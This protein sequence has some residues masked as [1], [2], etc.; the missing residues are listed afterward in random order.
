MRYTLH[1]PGE[2]R[3]V[4]SNLHGF[5][6][7][8]LDTGFKTKWSGFWVP[9]YKFLDYFALKV[10]GVWLDE[11]TL[12][13]VEY[14]EDFVFH[15]ETDS[16]KI[17]EKISAPP[18]LPG[19]R[20][21]LQMENK[22][23]SPKAIHAVVEPGIDIREKSEDL[24]DEDYT[25]ETTDNRLLASR[26]GKKLV[27]ESEDISDFSGRTE[28][29][30][31]YP[32]E[33]Q[34]CVIPPKPV[35]RSEIG[36]GAVE[37]FE[38][39]FKTS[40]GVFGKVES[41]EQQL[42]HELGRVFSC[43]I[44]SLENLT[45][46]RNGKGIIAGHPWFQDYWARDSFWSIMGYIDAGYFDLSR[47]ILENFAEKGISGKIG[48]EAD[49]SEEIYRADTEPLFIIAS[50]KLRRHSGTSPVIERARGKAIEKLETSENIVEHPP[51]GTW[52]DTLEREKAVEIQSL[53]LE[54]AE[55]M[56]DDRKEELEKGLEE[57]ENGEKYRDEL[58]GGHKTVNPAIPLM[59]GQAS[60][61]VAQKQ[62]EKI[63]GEFSSRYGARTRSVT[64]PG[65]ESAGYHT[66][67][68]WGLTTCWA[69]A[70]NLNY[71]K[72]Q[73]GVNMLEKL[74]SMLDRNQPGA[75][76]EVV[77]AESGELLGASE[78]A[79]SAGMLLHVADSYLLGINVGDDRVE[80]DPAGEVS[81][82]RMGK[83]VGEQSLDLEFQDG[84]VEV[85][86]D[87]ELEIR[88]GERVNGE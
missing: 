37:N 73:E 56:G 25:V 53:W 42:Q 26:K 45:Y 87:P 69:A 75:F 78:Q 76:P 10:N 54:A 11:G 61:E 55:I 35:F 23:D 64:D 77:D 13:A 84:K 70:A 66:G 86:N 74:N 52:M 27:I 51:E 43:S 59:F 81:C 15:H 39:D 68:V 71:G 3:G 88:T 38:M 34:L 85:L 46:A 9:P 19:F 80:I 62:L 8:Y 2:K 67:S 32:G 44:E 65:Y 16:M 17:T 36:G 48:L 24:S 72:L 6:L 29:K 14:G 57:F 82:R 79:W 18:D 50:E 1:E 21:E 83:R 47:E 41:R 22:M 5:L 63:N 33:R 7:R 60:E 40:E 58:E 28:W 31:H 30:Q 49:N 4:V 20:I 12:Q